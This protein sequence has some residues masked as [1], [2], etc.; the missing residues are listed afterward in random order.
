MIYPNFPKKCPRKLTTIHSFKKKKNHHQ[1]SGDKSN[2]KQ[3]NRNTE[4]HKGII[5]IRKRLVKKNKPGTGTDI[6][7]RRRF[8]LTFCGREFH[9]D[10][11]HF[12]DLPTSPPEKK[13]KHTKKNTCLAKGQT[14]QND[15]RRQYW[16]PALM[17]ALKRTTRSRIISTNIQTRYS[18]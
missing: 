16:R 6:Q 9:Q 5:I 18:S 14:R 10:G 11:W 15:F 3:K 17:R 13:T 12:W 8:N 1:T 4:R 2:K 7:E